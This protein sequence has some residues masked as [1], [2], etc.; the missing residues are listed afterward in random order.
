[1]LRQYFLRGGDAAA[2]RDLDPD[3]AHRHLGAGDAAQEHALVEVAQVADPEEPARHAGEAGTEGE[4]VAPVGDVDH[5]GAVDP[6]RTRM[7]LTVSEFHLGARAQSSR[8]QAFTAARV[9]SASR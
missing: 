2:R 6:G 5:L 4:V 8:P 3:V 7:A 1:M 9:P